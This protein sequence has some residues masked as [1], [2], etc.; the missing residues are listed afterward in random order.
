M[1]SLGAEEKLSSWTSPYEVE[2]H[3]GRCLS[4][5]SEG[6]RETSSLRG[7]EGYWRGDRQGNTGSGNGEDSETISVA[8]R[9]EVSSTSRHVITHEG[10]YSLMSP[11]TVVE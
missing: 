7:E 9:A 5:M 10:S 6:M 3:L 1:I 11:H 8:T 4:V 2:I